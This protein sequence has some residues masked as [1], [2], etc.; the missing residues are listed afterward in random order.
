VAAPSYSTDNSNN[1]TGVTSLAISKPATWAT[2]DV[3]FA[4]VQHNANEAVTPSE[5]GWTQVEALS[6]NGHRLYLWWRVVGAS[7]PASYT[8]T[9]ATSGSASGTIFRA[10]GASSTTPIDT[11]TSI[12]RA[13]ADPA[14]APSVTTTATDTLLVVICAAQGSAQASMTAAPTMTDREFITAGAGRS[15]LVASQTLSSAGA[16]GTRSVDLGAAATT[17]HVVVAIKADA[18]STVSKSDSDSATA[19]ENTDVDTSD[20]GVIA[21]YPSMI[22]GT[23]R[24]VSG[25]FDGT[26][27]YSGGDTGGCHRAPAATGLFSGFNGGVGDD[28]SGDYIP[29][30]RRFACIWGTANEVTFSLNGT[31]NAGGIMRLKEGESR[32]SIVTSTY[33]GNGTNTNTDGTSID[34]SWPRHTG[35]R[36]AILGQTVWAAVIR[37]A[38]PKEGIVYSRSGGDVG[39]W[40]TFFYDASVSRE[41][42]GLAVSPQYRTSGSAV[43][44]GV[45]RGSSTAGGVYVFRNA[46]SASPVASSRIDTAGNGG[47]NF[48][49]LMDVAVV[50]EGSNDVL[51]VLVGPE[52]AT[53]GERG[54]WRCTLSGNV[55]SGSYTAAWTQISTG[56]PSATSTATTSDNWWTSIIAA[57]VADSVSSDPNTSPIVGTATTRPVAFA[58][59]AWTSGAGDDADPWG[60]GWDP[61]PTGTG[62]DD[63]YNQKPPVQGRVEV[64]YRAPKSDGTM[65]NYTYIGGQ[66]HRARKPDGTYAESA[67]HLVRVDALTGELDT[68]WLPQ[69]QGPE[70]LYH[71]GLVRDIT[72]LHDPDGSGDCLLVTGEFNQIDGDTTHAKYLAAFRIRNAAGTDVAPTLVTTLWTTAAGTNRVDLNTYGR[73][74]AVDPDDKSLY[75]G[76]NFTTVNGS[77]RNHLAKLTLS[78]GTYSLSTWMDGSNP[79]GVNNTGL[80]T[81]DNLGTNDSGTPV[82]GSGERYWQWVS[83][84]AVLPSP[85]DRVIIGGFWETINGR[86][87]STE[88]YLCAV[89]KTTGGIASWTDKIATGANTNIDVSSAAADQDV[90]NFPM[91][92]MVLIKES[93]TWYL[94]SGHGGTN[95]A[96]KWNAETGARQWYWW[97]D[98]GI[99]SVGYF[100]GRPYFG[101]HDT[102]IAPV[103]EGF[104]KP[105]GTF[106]TKERFGI[107]TVSPDGNTLYDYGNSAVGANGPVFNNTGEESLRVWAIHGTPSGYDSTSTS[108]RLYV[109][110]GF[111]KVGSQTGAAATSVRFALFDATASS[112]ETTK[113]IIGN[114]GSTATSAGTYTRYDTTS[115]NYVKTHWR[116][117]NADT[118][119]TW[120]HISGSS[121]V[122]TTVYGLDEEWTAMTEATSTG[123]ND[124]RVGGASFSTQQLVYDSLNG[125]VCSFGKSGVWR[126]DNPWDATPV[127]RPMVSGLGAIVSKCVV[128]HPTDANSV[129]IADSDRSAWR[130][131]DGG[132]GQPAVNYMADFSTPAGNVTC[133]CLHY[134]TTDARMVG[135][136]KDNA[137]YRNTNPWDATAP[138]QI[139]D[140]SSTAPGGG[141]QLGTIRFRDTGGNDVWLVVTTSSGVRKSTDDGNTWTTGL[142]SGSLSFVSGTSNPSSDSAGKW[143]VARNGSDKVWLFAPGAATGAGLWYSSNAGTSFT[144]IW[145][146]NFAIAGTADRIFGRI[147]A[148][149]TVANTLFVTF[150]DGG[151]WRITNADNPGANGLDTAASSV[152]YTS[153]TGTIRADKVGPNITLGAIGVDPTRGDIVV[154]APAV[155][156]VD[157]TYN[158][159]GGANIYLGDSNGDAWRSV[160]DTGGVYEHLGY[161]PLD[162]AKLG[163]RIYV[164][165][166]GSG[167]FYGDVGGVPIVDVNIISSADS[168]TL[169]ESRPAVATTGADSATLAEGVPARSLS[170]PADSA[171]FAEIALVGPTTTDSGALSEAAR[172]AVTGSASEGV[173]F[174]DSGSLATTTTGQTPKSAS[175]DATLSDNG[176]IVAASTTSDTAAVTDSGT[177]SAAPIGTDSAALSE[178]LPAIG[179]P[180]T[181]QAT[182]NETAVV[183]PTSTDGAI[184]TETGLIGQTTTDSVTL[185][186]T[187]TVAGQLPSVDS[188]SFS[189]AGSVVTVQTGTDSGTLTDITLALTVTATNT[190]TISATETVPAVALTG[191][192]D[193]A[194][195]TDSGTETASLT[196]TD[197]AAMGDDGT[198][199]TP[200]LAIETATLAETGSAVDTLAHEDSATL[201]ET[202]ALA[203][204][205]PATDT[206]TL[207]DG[208]AVLV[209]FADTD[210]AILADDAQNG[211]I[212]ARRAT[213]TKRKLRITATER[214]VELP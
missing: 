13:S 29:D 192:S 184:L 148:H 49:G 20:S 85:H 72:V 162:V 167:V 58:N 213:S 23:G 119:P 9:W 136:R 10:G 60:V 174:T 95:L 122:D 1:A 46:D 188:G 22:D 160:K 50:K 153:T 24:I 104:K 45:A 196:S 198:L 73:A 25:G 124:S 87:P 48:A 92:D 112:S 62:S 117:T 7:D 31:R 106:L 77:T 57:R 12:A 70:S 42:T 179:L 193:S 44:Y 183:G 123:L 90:H 146:K 206:A 116:A 89:N 98:G 43:L 28:G 126:C 159:S 182:L 138:Y 65:G 19:T 56:L 195:V 34:G 79:G 26:Y 71:S 27:W 93:G 78:G 86:G 186:D 88:K 32:F 80:T 176:S 17:N 175:E 132:A 35:N 208:A 69:L 82:F 143:F 8:F 199:G 74:V 30:F 11:S 120:A 185:T 101:K 36:G 139:F 39:S 121:N 173:A 105:T 125:V 37:S 180:L 66:F 145:T 21:W 201:S 91:F 209:P 157:A 191:P 189:D 210:S 84:I 165:T 18:V 81:T 154:C 115:A 15:Q 202:V 40:S 190:E 152:L 97:S 59:P 147:A 169:S 171:A 76:G 4:A 128:V 96:A 130:W 102:N 151:V 2:G 61:D 142:A 140:D 150:K 205:I 118:T 67:R 127:W 99:Q 161:A 164:T 75:L 100:N 33:W 111:G 5:S 156:D 51:Y 47:A 113:L 3:V 135:S 200:F 68:A 131:D 107:F 14:S 53:S 134:N 110:G 187:G 16:T 63:N 103:K 172:V 178:A 170:G 38:S 204:D 64:I 194:T 114:M 109:G 144:R 203:I 41:F 149:A 54:V 158:P 207:T 168:A 137:V 108:T 211:V 6:G 55:A 177:P 141:D 212:F 166:D 52:H 214:K 94:Y 133:N 155:A 197:S 83:R 129:F 163:T 181:D